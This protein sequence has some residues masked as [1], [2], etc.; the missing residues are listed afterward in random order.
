MG[1]PRL[2][3]GQSVAAL[4]EAIDVIRALWDTG[5]PGGARVEGAHHRLDGAA[6]GPAPLHDV[7]IWVGAYKPRMLDLV[8]RKADGWLPSRPHLEPG[9]LAAGNAAIDEAADR[10]GRRPSEIRRLLNLAGGVPS[11]DDLARLA[12]EDGVGTF[13]VMADDPVVIEAFAGE[14]APAV[15]AQVEPG[16]R[17][18]LVGRHLIDVHDM[19]R[20]ELAELRDILGQV[21]D[22]ALGPGRADVLAGTTEGPAGAGPS[23]VRPR[24][25]EPPRPIRVTRPSTLRVYQFRH[26]RVGRGSI[27][28]A[29]IPRASWIS[30]HALVASGTPVRVPEAHPGMDDLTDRQSAILTFIS[31]HCR[32]TGYPP[33][34]R[35][36]GLAVG[37]A[38]PSTVHAHLA[39]LESGGH[40]RRDPTKPR[41]MFVCRDA[42]EA[43]PAPRPPPRPCRSSA[44]WPPACRASPSRTSRSGSPRPS[45]ATSC[46]ASPATR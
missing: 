27:D 1:G 20:T 21:R 31:R 14:V 42:V 45:R 6:R 15:R 22:G 26:R 41:A 10:A 19:L 25:L 18:Q 23:S 29:G 33:T 44:P 28:E 38:S 5:R 46:S 34:V 11:A 9:A 30:P 24:G 2:T 37:L 16:A 39:K 36:I 35:E 7:G 3:P 12:V 13:I 32:E 43:A 17:G 4:E 8:G 40:I